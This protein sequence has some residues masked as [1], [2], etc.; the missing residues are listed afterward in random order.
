MEISTYANAVPGT[1]YRTLR[2]LPVAQSISISLLIG[3]G[4]YAETYAPG[5]QRRQT[6]IYVTAEKFGGASLLEIIEQE[7]KGDYNVKHV[8]N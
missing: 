4:V 7:K 5:T 8:L 2:I 1:R 3:G 6:Q